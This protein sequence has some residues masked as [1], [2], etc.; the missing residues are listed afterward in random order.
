MS[1][2]PSCVDYSDSI[3]EPRLIKAQ[4]L[5]GGHCVKKNDRQIKYSGGFCI[6]FPFE[7][8]TKKYAVRCWHVNVQDAKERIRI[9]AE[10]LHRIKLPYFVGFE[11]VDNGI[12][13]PQGLQPIVLMDWVD[14]K[15]LKEYIA[16]NNSDS[17]CLN[18]LADD[19]MIMVSQLHK[20]NLSHGDLQ[21]GNIL[22]KQDGSLIL[23]DYDSMF[24]PALQGK[25]DEI[26]GLKGYQHEARW[27]N[28]FLTPKADYF[29][30]LVIY[31]SIK[32]ISN[33]PSLWKDLNMDN[34]ETMLFSSEDIKSKGQAPIFDILKSDPQLRELTDKLIEF[35]NCSSIDDLTPLEK[36]VTSLLDSIS[37]KWKDNGYKPNPL[38]YTTVI[39]GITKKW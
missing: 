35:M 22:V 21:H 29:S 32:A 8:P 33:I 6:V 13:T 37:D 24:V 9:I 5:Q 2:L 39:T 10:E 11:Y 3:D 34:T 4:A 20:N 27:S 23:V 16:L 15:S 26:K 18:K 38:D 25:I 30:E 12:A 31:L 14:A 1:G 19:F 36:S 28:K 17:A 7:T